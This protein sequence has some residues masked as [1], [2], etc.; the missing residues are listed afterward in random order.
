MYIQSGIHLLKVT[1]QGT[2][3]TC[4]AQADSAT[5]LLGHPG[6]HGWEEGETVSDVTTLLFMSWCL[7]DNTGVR[8]GEPLDLDMLEES[9]EWHGIGHIRGLRLTRT[10]GK[11]ATR[12]K[13]GVEKRGTAY[14]GQTKFRG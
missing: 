9:P 5:Q 7:G 14:G 10:A 3:V 6:S 2:S 11:D 1:N 13:V 4:D 8:V 12:V